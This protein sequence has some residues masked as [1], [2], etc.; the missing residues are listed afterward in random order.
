VVN[1]YISRTV[2]EIVQIVSYIVDISVLKC[3][4]LPVAEYRSICML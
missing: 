3:Y 1:D 2:K 4:N